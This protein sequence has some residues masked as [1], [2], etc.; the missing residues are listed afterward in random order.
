MTL[1]CQSCAN[2]VQ[3]KI[4]EAYEEFENMPNNYLSGTIGALLC[5]IPGV[6]V[7]FIFFLLGKLAAVSGVVYYILAL[8][9]YMWFKGKFNKVGVIITGVISLV[10]TAA[11]T[12]VSY[13]A[14]LIKEV[15]KYPDM[16][17]TP[18][19]TVIPYVFEA[20]KR[21]DVKKEILQ[22]VY[23]S[24]FLCGICIIYYVIDGLKQ[25]KKTQLK[26]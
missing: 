4:D 20:V 8:K 1:F 5:A 2:K 16:K 10:Y 3:K 19:G 6:I 13:V 12:Y 26:K 25:T 14:N 11:G 18:L 23:L 7:T 22:N 24:L 15:Y 21:P 9:G 17:G